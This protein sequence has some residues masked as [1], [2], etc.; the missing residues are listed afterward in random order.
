MG[1]GGC[2]SLPRVGNLGCLTQVRYGNCKSITAHSYQC[3]QAA[4]TWDLFDVHTDVDA[5]DCTQ[6]LYR[7]SA[8]PIP[9]NV[10]RLPIFGICLMCT[11]MLMH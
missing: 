6:G 1:G 5:L 10:S 9:I 3:V 7:Y 4:N 11:Q 2:T 8:L